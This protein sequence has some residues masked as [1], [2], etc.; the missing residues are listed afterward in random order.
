MNHINYL[1]SWFIKLLCT[2]LF[3]LLLIIFLIYFDFRIWKNISGLLNTIIGTLFAITF[4]VFI[5]WRQQKDKY[6][7]L[8]KALFNYLSYLDERMSNDNDF[9]DKD[10]DTIIS[11]DLVN[12]SI[13]NKMIESGFFNN[14]NANLIK[15]Q[16]AIE[17]Y[18]TFVETLFVKDHTSK[19]DILS[20]LKL[21]QHPQGIIHEET[22]KILS[23]NSN[24]K[25][26]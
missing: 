18:H 19:E 9:Q 14:L 4:G 1:K 7:A 20:S 16:A 21:I 10:I 13:I 17:L 26:E 3:S 12:K 8:R 23:I 6:D 22:Q 15:L 2:S 11:L 24:A 5:Y 25:P